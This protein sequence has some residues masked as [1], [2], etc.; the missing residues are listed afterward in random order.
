[1][2]FTVN[3]I[4]FSAIAIAI[5]SSIE[6][7]KSILASLNSRI[8]FYSFLF[9]FYFGYFGYMT[10]SWHWDWFCLVFYLLVFCSHDNALQFWKYL[11]QSICLLKAIN[12]DHKQCC[13]FTIFSP[14]E[15]EGQFLQRNGFFFLNSNI[16][17][18]QANNIYCILFIVH[19]TNSS[20][21]AIGRNDRH[22]VCKCKL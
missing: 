8:Y 15:K 7:R 17:P 20:H 21:N 13:Q 22:V 14:M 12:D 2:E 11:R 9:R 18:N 1:M 4:I 6:T 16:K 10:F 19:D 3:W 5:G